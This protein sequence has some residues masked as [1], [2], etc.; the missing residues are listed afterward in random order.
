M[1]RMQI[2]ATLRELLAKAKNYAAQKEAGANPPFDMKLESMLP[3]VKKEIPLKA[4]AHRAD[5]ILTS[6]R[7]AK[8]FDVDL[9]LDHCTEGHLIADRLAR[10][11]YPA[12]VGPFL[13]G[14]S[15]LELQN[16]GVQTAGILHKAD[17]N[18]CFV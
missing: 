11:G 1:T 7:I 16:K 8:E 4:H 13:P 17:L 9:T 18:A 10:E 12:I 5:D 3:V 2:A 6:I 15:K 14:K